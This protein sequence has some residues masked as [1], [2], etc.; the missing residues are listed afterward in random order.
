MDRKTFRKEVTLPAL[1]KMHKYGLS[2][3][4]VGNACLLVG[5]WISNNHAAGFD[6]AYCLNTAAHARKTGRI[7]TAYNAIS[8]ARCARITLFSRHTPPFWRRAS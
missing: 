5:A 2:Y 3:R 7:S 8:T 1:R 6:I 4:F